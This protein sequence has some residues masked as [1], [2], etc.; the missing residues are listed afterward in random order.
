MNEWSG[1]QRSY[2]FRKCRGQFHHVVGN[3]GWVKGW[4]SRMQEKQQSWKTEGKRCPG[5]H[6]PTSLCVKFEWDAQLQSQSAALSDALWPG[7][8]LFPEAKNRSRFSLFLLMPV[9]YSGYHVS[10]S[11]P[12]PQASPAVYD[13]LILYDLLVL[14]VLFYSS[15]FM[16]ILYSVW[17]TL[18]SPFPFAIVLIVCIGFFFMLLRLMSY[19]NFLFHKCLLPL[20]RGL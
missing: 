9:F 12:V 19:C 2:T 3:P 20:S 13:S 16:L 14:F 8:P 6:E 10:R 11:C 5:S 17:F 4:W 15:H 7:I 18:L 1:P